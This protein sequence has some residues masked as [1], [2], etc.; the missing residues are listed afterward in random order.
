MIDVHQQDPALPGNDDLASAIERV[1]AGLSAMAGGDP[2]P[3]KQCWADAPDVT[4]FGAWGPIE[5]GREALAATF[6]WVGSR[7]RG[8]ELKPTY[9]TIDVSGDLAVTVGFERGEVSV[10]GA[11]A[12]PM[13]I[14]VTH[15]YR[16][17]GGQWRLVHRH[18]DFPPGGSASP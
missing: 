11:P 1:A 18:A 16:R 5:Q 7:F 4:L 8:G 17:S 9:E 2:E 6:D 12:Q 13:T 10:D 14:R 3:Y 15:V